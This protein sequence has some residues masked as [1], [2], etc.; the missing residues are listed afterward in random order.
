MSYSS[1]IIDTLPT[2]V[3]AVTNYLPHTILIFLLTVNSEEI[4]S[5]D[6]DHQL[7]C[8]ITC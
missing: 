8:V 7:V 6:Y 4:G 1:S 2:Y 3:T 5:F